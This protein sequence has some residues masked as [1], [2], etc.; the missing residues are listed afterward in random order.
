VESRRNEI[1]VGIA[2]VISLMM[3]VGGIMWGK[4]YRLKATRYHITVV[5]ENVGGLENGAN[6]LC[7]GVVQ[8]QVS[9]VRLADGKVL[10]DAAINKN[11]VLY[12]DYRATI[13][14]PT[15]MSGKVL[16]F[17]PGSKM[18]RADISQPLKGENPFGMGEAVAVFEKV[19]DDF[20]TALHN[21]NTLVVNLNLI[22][23][24][25]AN[26]KNVAGV[27]SNANNAAQTTN[28]WLTENRA[29]I[30]MTLSE[31]DSTLKTAHRLIRTVE[32]RMNG[33]LDAAD[34]AAVQITALSSSLHGLV[35]KMARGEG[36]VGK[37]ITNDELYQR[38]NKTLASVDSLTNYI[39]V[40][41]INTHI[42]LF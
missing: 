24:D 6:V 41:G 12:S 4:G 37:L 30:T 19:S 31:L 20:Q 16:S 22:V 9:N 35:E 29:R 34:S 3:L 26:R 28:E 2:V 15:V 5:F 8:G 39:R 13:E 36:T 33:T 10:V 11:V 14:S 40:H 32:S 7:N 27:L 25:S 18:P 23:G 1:K 38:L 42:K 21:V 17:M